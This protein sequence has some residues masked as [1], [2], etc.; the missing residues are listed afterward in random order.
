VK[1][2]LAVV[3]LKLAGSSLNWSG[4]TY[5]SFNFY[6]IYFFLNCKKEGL[7]L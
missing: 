3:C 1:L 4:C 2:R 5:I 6:D 7:L